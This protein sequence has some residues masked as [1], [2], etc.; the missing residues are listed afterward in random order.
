[1]PGQDPDEV[2]VAG[3][4]DIY[5]APVGTAF[6]ANIDAAIPDGFS[7]VGYVTEEGARFSFGRE[8]NEIM[9]WQSR[10]PIRQVVTAI[11]K[12]VSFDV[13]QWNGRTAKL[14]LGGG[15][16]TETAAGA[17][18]FEPPDEDYIDERAFI[19]VGLDGDKNYRFCFRR[20]TNEAGVEFAFVRDNPAVLPITLKVLAAGGGLKSY[21][22]QTDDPSFGPADVPFVP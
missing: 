7:A 12:T 10:D 9:A 3:F 14:A 1:M 21:F 5:E 4:G 17:F 6:P 19:V 13:Q 2:L 15:T 18:E 8:L 11:P 16:I 20:A 22:V